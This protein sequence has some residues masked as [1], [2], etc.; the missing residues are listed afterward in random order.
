MLRTLARPVGT[1][2]SVKCHP[3][4][5]ETGG[6]YTVE[7]GGKRVGPGRCFS[8]AEIAERYSGF[9]VSM[10]PSDGPWYTRGWEHDSE[11]R[12]RAAKVASWI[13]SDAFREE[14]GRSLVVLV[15]H[16]HFI[17]TLQKMMVGVADDPAKDPHGEYTHAYKQT[18][19]QSNKQQNTN[20]NQP[21]NLNS[22]LG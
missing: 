19:N 21:T 1:D 7:P 20:A 18:S 13:R 9:D 4:I 3:D 15:M 12:A 2:I 14:H 17:D 8:A 16:G 5:Y 6:V 11:A 10:L 22:A